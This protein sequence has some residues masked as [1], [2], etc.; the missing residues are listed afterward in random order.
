MVYSLLGFGV[1]NKAV[2]EFFIKRKEKVFVSEKRK[3]SFEEKEYLEKLNIPYEEGSHTE[4]AL[5]CDVIVVSPG[6]NPEIDIIKKAKK[7][8]IPITTEF[9]IFLENASNLL[10]KVIG[11]TGTNGKSTTVSMLGYLLKKFGKKVFVGGN[12]GTPSIKALD[13]AYDYIVLEISSFQ[14][15]W[16][17][18]PKL[19]LFT[20]L[21]IKPD[22]L[23]WHK[24]FE[25]Y[26]LSKMK[27]TFFMENNDKFF[28]NGR[29]RFIKPYLNDIKA[30]KIPFWSDMYTWED[31]CIKL[32]GKKYNVVNGALKTE[33]NKE[34]VLAVLSIMDNLGYDLSI[35]L[36]HLEEFSFLD[37]RMEFL[38]EWNGIMFFNDSKSTN[39]SA[40]ETALR[41]FENG[42]VILIM[43]G[44]SKKEPD[45]SLNSL[46]DTI[47]EKAKKVIIFGS[48]KKVISHALKESS[49]DV[50]ETR[51]M[52]KSV[53]KAL[54]EAKM[55][56][57]ILLSPGGSSFDMYKNYKERGE[58]FK[59][60]VKKYLKGG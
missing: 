53:E 25:E 2:L 4:K 50:V 35:S 18:K 20:V 21:N 31:E 3:L 1:S 44:I 8:G 49:V 14:L 40:V 42:K 48:M 45:D 36:N 7:K 24:S 26:I 58:H 56:D 16:T 5:N 54:K 27:P 6:I 11:V 29:D 22:H 43:C 34:N 9:Q 12:L 59:Q 46:I 17:K 41:N 52:E 28:F 30:I 57:V 60:I 13:E 19:K 39:F 55:G 15:F 23:D 37:N 10:E 51:N 32:K 47:K 38:G 33:Q